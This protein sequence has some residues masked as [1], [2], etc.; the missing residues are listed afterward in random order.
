MVTTAIRSIRSARASAL[1]IWKISHGVRQHP[2]VRLGRSADHRCAA[3]NRTAVV[4]SPDWNK[5]AIFEVDLDR[6][7]R[8]S[9]RWQPHGRLAK[10]GIDDI[11][12]IANKY[13]SAIPTMMQPPILEAIVCAGRLLC[14]TTLR[15]IGYPRP[16]WEQTWGAPLYRIHERNY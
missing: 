5:R 10:R 3:S 8:V 9:Q 12:R 6:L 15:P 4:H 7:A 1:G 14:R 2:E 11:P 16:A 13:I